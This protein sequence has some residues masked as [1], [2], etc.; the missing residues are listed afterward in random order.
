MMVRKMTSARGPSGAVTNLGARCSNRYL[1]PKP[2][3]NR[4]LARNQS[5]RNP[6]K[7]NRDQ[8]WSLRT[9]ERVLIGKSAT[10]TD[11][12]PVSALEA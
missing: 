2:L 1:Y 9:L 12:D 5:M 3:D 4:C 10:H 8:N 11:R 7:S 6:I